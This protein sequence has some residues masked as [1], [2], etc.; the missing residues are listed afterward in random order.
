VG[1][2]RKFRGASIVG[3]CE[4]GFAASPASGLAR[5]TCSHNLGPT[6]SV[7]SGQGNAPTSLTSGGAQMDLG[8]P[9]PRGQSRAA[10]GMPPQPQSSS[11]THGPPARRVAEAELHHTTYG[12]GLRPIR[13]MFHAP[14]AGLGGGC[15]EPARVLD[16]ARANPVAA[17]HRRVSPRSPRSRSP[18]IQTPCPTRPSLILETTTSSPRVRGAKPPLGHESTRGSGRWY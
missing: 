6:N 13:P 15:V 18:G 12:G 1:S 5:L 14:D 17:T 2:R 9:G 10:A 11:P 8:P 7:P 3:A 16:A 4:Q